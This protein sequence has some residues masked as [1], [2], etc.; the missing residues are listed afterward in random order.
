MTANIAKLVIFDTW[1]AGNARETLANSDVLDLRHLTQAD[2]LAVNEP[3]LLTMHAVS[4]THLR[5]HETS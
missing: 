5:A 4:Y 1:M 3:E 2:G